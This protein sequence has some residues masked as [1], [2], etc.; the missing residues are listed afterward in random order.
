MKQL[1][2][3]FLSSRLKSRIPDFLNAT[4]TNSFNKNTENNFYGPVNFIADK[5]KRLKEKTK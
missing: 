5:P 1:Q 4:F 2:E 3:G